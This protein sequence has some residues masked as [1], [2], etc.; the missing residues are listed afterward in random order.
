MDAWLTGR[1][2]LVF[3]DARFI[4]MHPVTHPSISGICGLL[5]LDPPTHLHATLDSFPILLRFSFYQTYLP[6]VSKFL[7]MTRSES[8]SRISLG[9]SSQSVSEGFSSLDQD[10][11]KE[12]ITEDLVSHEVCR[13]EDMLR[14]FV[15]RCKDT[16]LTPPTRFPPSPT[17]PEKAP[18][19]PSISPELSS[20]PD[21]TPAATSLDSSN[22]DLFEHCLKAAQGICN[23]PE[24]KQLL[25]K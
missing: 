6:V 11:V 4:R 14:V 10:D 3:P 12:W 21:V 23:L 22:M 7:S 13:I 19:V 25:T 20:Q 5:T 8:S 17:K 1:F 18:T 2:I 16:D 15:G 24:M 9:T